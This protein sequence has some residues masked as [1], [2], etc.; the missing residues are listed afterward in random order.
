MSND[1]YSKWSTGF[2][3]T[4][5][6]TKY[7]ELVSKLIEGLGNCISLRNMQLVSRVYCTN[8]WVE[9]FVISQVGIA[10]EKIFFL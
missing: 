2:Y 6:L 10:D 1:G 7:V 4:I 9:I 3:L 8:V 5:Y